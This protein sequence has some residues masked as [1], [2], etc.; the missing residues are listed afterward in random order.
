MQQS[1]VELLCAKSEPKGIGV[2]CKNWRPHG[3][4]GCR[5]AAAAPRGG[6]IKASVGGWQR[7]GEAAAGLVCY[8]GNVWRSLVGCVSCL[9][10]TPYACAWKAAGLGSANFHPLPAFPAFQIEGLGN[11]ES[12]K[13]GTSQMGG[14]GLIS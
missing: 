3:A 6:G 4:G 7:G 9:H 1:T 13:R 14:M 10:Q 2:G 11:L 5:S 12:W 8:S